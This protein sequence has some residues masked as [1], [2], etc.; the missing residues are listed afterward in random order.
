[1][2]CKWRRILRKTGKDYF[3]LAFLPGNPYNVLE[4]FDKICMEERK[5][6]LN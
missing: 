5:C 4:S 6:L 2:L 3:P 1:M